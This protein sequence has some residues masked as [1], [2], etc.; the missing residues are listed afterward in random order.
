LLNR[1]IS[2][3]RS[4]SVHRAKLFL[5]TSIQ[6]HRIYGY[7]QANARQVVVYY[8]YLYEYEEIVYL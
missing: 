3:E 6:A 8:R 4:Q 7:R 5:W 1:H 2:L